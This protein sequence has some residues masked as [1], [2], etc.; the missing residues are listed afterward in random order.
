MALSFDALARIK[1]DR[2]HGTLSYEQVSALIVTIDELM[3]ENERLRR[4]ATPT[5]ATSP[6]EERFWTRHDP[7]HGPLRANPGPVAC[8]PA[9]ARP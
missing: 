9:P 3:T 2:L 4:A 1:D 8:P 7:P 5:W 6:D